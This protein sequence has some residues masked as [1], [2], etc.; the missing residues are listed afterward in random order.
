MNTVNID[1]SYLKTIASD[2]NSFISEMLTMIQAS[3]SEEI[4]KIT[5]YY[6]EG[7]CLAIAST[8]HKI[9]APIQMINEHL[10]VDIVVE[11]ETYCRDGK[12]KE[13]IPALIDEFNDRFVKVNS[14]I[15][16]VIEQLNAIK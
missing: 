8:A 15:T 12:N 6:K 16:D 10:L 9:K 1:L 11:I 14:K 13:L 7:N 2:D 3:V 5:S 4:G